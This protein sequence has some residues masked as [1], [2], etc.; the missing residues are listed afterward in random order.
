MVAHNKGT[1]HCV[2]TKI[3]LINDIEIEAAILT[4]FL[5]ALIHVCIQTFIHKYMHTVLP[6]NIYNYRMK[7]FN[8]FWISIFPEFPYFWKYGK[9]GNT[10]MKLVV[11]CYIV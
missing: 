6:R 4:N 10:E 11:Y 3:Q 2:H 7:Y 9:S 1:M 8:K 5:K